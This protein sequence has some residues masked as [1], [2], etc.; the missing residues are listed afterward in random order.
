MR[1]R[2][3]AVDEDEDE[4]EK[5]DAVGNGDGEGVF[6]VV[7]VFSFSSTVIHT[8]ARNLLCK[9]FLGCGVD[10]LCQPD[11]S[12]HVSLSADRAKDCMIGARR[13][14]AAV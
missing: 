6:S 3:G 2:D 14:D 4:G 7:V 8:H 10:F 1:S 12:S 11:S 13:T 9:H 5:G